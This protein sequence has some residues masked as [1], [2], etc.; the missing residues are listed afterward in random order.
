MDEPKYCRG[1]EIS[2]LIQDMARVQGFT[3]LDSAR[4][5][6]PEEM[7]KSY[8]EHKEYWVHMTKA[9]KGVDWRHSLVGVNYNLIAS[10]VDLCISTVGEHAHDIWASILK[11]LKNRQAD[12]NKCYEKEVIFFIRKFQIHPFTLQLSARPS[13]N[14]Q[15]PSSQFLLW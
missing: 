7:G 10:K 2:K 15:A 3:D 4:R 6:I 13:R 1:A 12:K 5:L 14:P 8:P 9:H 11:P